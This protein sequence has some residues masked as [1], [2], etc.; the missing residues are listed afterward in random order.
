MLRRRKEA[1]VDRESLACKVRGAAGN[2]HFPNTGPVLILFIRG[3]FD[4][5]SSLAQH[6]SLPMSS[7]FYD[8]LAPSAA[9]PKKAASV[10]APNMAPPI[11]M[12]AL[13]PPP[14]K[15]TV[16]LALDAVANVAEQAWVAVP[17]LQD[18]RAKDYAHRRLTH[19]AKSQP[20]VVFS[21]MLRE[22]EML[23]RDAE[24]IMTKEWAT[25]KHAR[26]AIPSFQGEPRRLDPVFMEDAKP[27]PKRP[28]SWTGEAQRARRMAKAR[29]EG[30]AIR[31]YTRTIVQADGSRTREQLGNFAKQYNQDL[32]TD[33]E[34]ATQR[35][36]ELLGALKSPPPKKAKGAPAPA[37]R[38]NMTPE[39]KKAQGA[40][41]PAPRPKMT[42][43]EKKAAT[44]ER[45]VKAKTKAAANAEYWAKKA[46]SY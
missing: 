24:R 9:A 5:H 35:H 26:N 14:P 38:P 36:E 13:A 30:R 29:A 12:S 39:E 40:P 2:R 15:A 41:A 1:V 11:I 22:P 23:T 42:P 10:A 44:A 28:E 7:L 31:S 8:W 16:A 27:P 3:H 37:P 46:A 34:V 19:M 45:L 4:S 18:A 20:D 21:A 33:R 17:T 25:A 6:F 32:V 43:E